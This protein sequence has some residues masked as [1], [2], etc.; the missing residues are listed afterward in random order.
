MT[1]VGPFAA[2]L[3]HFGACLVRGAVNLVQG[4]GPF[5]ERRRLA[6]RAW[7]ERNQAEDL[8]ALE[9]VQREV[10]DLLKGGKS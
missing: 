8:A 10:D 7:V 5:M 4:V 9:S 6:Y 1:G 2:S 3:G